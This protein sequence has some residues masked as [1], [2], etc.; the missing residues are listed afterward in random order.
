[1]PRPPPTSPRRQARIA[2]LTEHEKGTIDV[3]RLDERA[4]L[5][6]C[7]FRFLAASQIDQAKSALFAYEAL[8]HKHTW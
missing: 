8:T 7:A 3:V 6:V 4:A 2:K 5:A 1:M